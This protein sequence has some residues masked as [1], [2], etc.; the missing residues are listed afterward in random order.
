MAPKRKCMQ[1]TVAQKL[2]LLQKLEW[3]A[4]VAKQTVSHI[5][6]A[7][8]SLQSFAMKYSPDSLTYMTTVGDHKLM[9]RSSAV[10]VRGIEI[11]MAAEKLATHLGISNFN[12][13]DGWLW[14]FRRKAWDC[15]PLEG[16]LLSQVY[17]ADENGPFWRMLPENTQALAKEQS[18]RGRKL[19]KDEDDKDENTGGQRTLQS[20]R[21]YDIEAAIFNWAAAWKDVKVLTLANSW[22]KLIQDVD[23]VD[24][25]EEFEV[26]DY[27]YNLKAGEDTITEENVLKWLHSDENDPGFQLMA[28]EEIAASCRAPEKDNDDDE[29]EDIILFAPKIGHCFEY[30]FA[31]TNEPDLKNYYSH[32]LE[33]RDLICRMQ[34]EINKQTKIDSFHPKPPSSQQD[35]YT[36]PY[37]SLLTCSWPFIYTHTVGSII[38]HYSI[39][40][41]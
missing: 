10:A 29:D 36:L 39:L 30:L 21:K 11:Q 14:R 37:F 1:L 28:E 8:V 2:E 35:S 34:L 27:N 31:N 33:L 22:K 18:T 40:A 24:D 15:Q 4:C 20:L 25:F 23:H 12:A 3:L 38:R 19:D 16:L 17:N 6:K 41:V 9:R 7:K 5:R 26:A 32:I 13:S